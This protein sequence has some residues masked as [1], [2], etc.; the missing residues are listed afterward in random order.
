MAVGGS[1]AVAAGLLGKATVVAVPAQ[2]GSAINIAS[3]I[4]SASPLLAGA[5]VG[6]VV[7]GVAYVV[8]SR[9]GSDEDVVTIQPAN[10]SRQDDDAEQVSSPEPA[11][12]LVE[13]SP[14]RTARHMAA[15]GRAG[16]PHAPR[17]FRP[18]E[19]EQTGTIL[20]QEVNEPK[21]G[22]H[23]STP[24]STSRPLAPAKQKDEDYAEVAENYVKL[25]TL[26]RRMA[27]TAR[28]VAA[29]LGERLGGSMMEGI[30]VIQ[31][32]DGTVAD[33][34]TTWWDEAIAASGHDAVEIDS[35]REVM[36]QPDE[37]RYAPKATSSVSPDD[38]APQSA[39]M[40]PEPRPALTFSQAAAK[41][42][43]SIDMGKFPERRNAEELDGKKDVWA[44]ALEAL[45]E[46]ASDPLDLI[47]TDVVGDVD[48][49]DEPDGLEMPTDFIPFRMP[50]GHPEVVDADSYVDYLIR[51]EFTKNPSSAV[52]RNARE[53]LHV[54]EGGTAGM[55]RDAGARHARR[56]KHFKADALPLAM[57]A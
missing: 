55:L 17:H 50:A 29:V 19:W 48:T 32:A 42:L 22:A 6:A 4:E 20:V 15:S 30:P 46:R 27:I 54:I 8:L 40:R 47:F 45:D 18:A 39:E 24:D 43:A 33:V 35:S 10:R 28:G 38:T 13:S 21:D 11:V 23:A 49:L 7:G 41:R 25:T 53:Y 57:E 14:A 31:R 34:G 36:V 2:V 1:Q 9:I 56:G 51:Q 52:R 16:V 37:I 12:R 26:A 3:L 5:A 44:A